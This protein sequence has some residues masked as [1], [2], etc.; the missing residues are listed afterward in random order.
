MEKALGPGRSH[1]PPMVEQ[2]PSQ[3][4][5]TRQGEP[6][7]PL[8]TRQEVIMRND[9]SM[10]LEQAAARLCS[11]I[12][13]KSVMDM[14]AHR[15]L[16]DEQVNHLAMDVNKSVASYRSTSPGCKLNQNDTTSNSAS[17]DQF[18]SNL[19][20]LLLEINPSNMTELDNISA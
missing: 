12:C 20:T 17:S 1:T 18:P 14:D 19:K 11:R 9:G 16:I 10:T 8:L 5:L 7:Q 2:E 13:T 3:P 15:K 6:S 4:P